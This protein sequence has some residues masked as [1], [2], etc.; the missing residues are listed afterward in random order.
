MYL[1]KFTVLLKK[2]DIIGLYIVQLLFK[3][4]STLGFTDIDFVTARIYTIH[5]S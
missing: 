3:I 5:E 2:K 1:L 4:L